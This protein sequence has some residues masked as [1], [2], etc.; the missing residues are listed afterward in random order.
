VQCSL[1]FAWFT[2]AVLFMLTLTLTLTC[3]V[4]FM[5]TLTQ[6][7]TCA[8][9][10]ML[11]PPPPTVRCR[12]DGLEGKVTKMADLLEDQIKK[13]EVHHNPP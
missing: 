5:V 7:L 6:T 4:I 2:C 12:H 10:F 9:R 1:C 8:V 3:A 13:A 11:T